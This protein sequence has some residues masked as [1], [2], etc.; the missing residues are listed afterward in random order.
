VRS[1]WTGKKRPPFDFYQY[2]RNID[3]ADVVNCLKL[4]TFIS[5]EEIRAM[6][7]LKD[8]AINEAKKRLPGK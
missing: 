7:S 6:A 2:W 1:G 4:M 8:E 3:D 5:L